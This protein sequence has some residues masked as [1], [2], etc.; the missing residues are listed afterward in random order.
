MIETLISIV[1]C[2]SSAITVLIL[3]LPSQYQPK[4]AGPPLRSPETKSRKAY[5]QILVLGDI[6]RSPRMQYHALSIAKHGGEVVI[7]GYNE[8]DPHPDIMSNPNISIVPL[9]PHPAFLHTSNKLLF[10]IYG[11]LKV[12]FQIACLWKSLAYT[13]KPSQWLLVQY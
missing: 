13:T 1:F 9:R 7:I 12:L 4:Q 5:V 8:S 11:P 3:L 6:G 10:T 2:L